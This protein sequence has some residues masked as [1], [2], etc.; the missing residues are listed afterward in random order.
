MIPLDPNDLVEVVLPEHADEPSETRPVLFC[1]AGSVGFWRRL[2]QQIDAAGAEGSAEVIVRELGR[3]ITAGRNLRTFDGQPI[4]W[5]GPETLYEIMSD[6][7][8]LMLPADLRSAVQLGDL[9]KKALRRQ[10]PS[11]AEESAGT[12]DP[13]SA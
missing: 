13:A 11:A 2:R 12:A 4:T 1:R 10:S 5:E 8:L 9:E 7:G 6:V 3:I